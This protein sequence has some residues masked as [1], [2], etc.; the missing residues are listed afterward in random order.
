MGSL[1]GLVGIV[2]LLQLPA[3]IGLPVSAFLNLS[4]LAIQL[5]LESHPLAL[6]LCLVVL[7][8]HQLALKVG[9]V[10]FSGTSGGLRLLDSL[11]GLVVAGLILGCRLLLLLNLLHQI[12][13][14]Q[15]RFSILGL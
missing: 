5:L 13:D 9:P 2:S 4:H 11:Q 12:L 1:K 15:V 10:L 8:L 3:Q 14:F 7:T 6:N